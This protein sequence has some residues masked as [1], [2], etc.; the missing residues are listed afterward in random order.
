MLYRASVAV[1]CG[2]VLVGVT[3]SGGTASAD[4]VEVRSNTQCASGCVGTSETGTTHLPPTTPT[5]SNSRCV[6]V[7]NDYPW[8]EVII[9]E[10]WTQEPSHENASL[11]S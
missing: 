7:E 10:P 6:I 3:F 11:S 4:P 1:M 2:G 5:E 9:C 8:V